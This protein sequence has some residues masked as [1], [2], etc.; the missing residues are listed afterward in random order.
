MCGKLLAYAAAT[1]AFTWVR[2]TAA[3]RRC[4]LHR[5]RGCLLTAQ[6][7][8]SELQALTVEDAWPRALELPRQALPVPLVQHQLLQ[9]AVQQPVVQQAAVQAAPADT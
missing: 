1:T 6:R 8:L 4:D 7:W 2:S 5:C 9:V 3:G